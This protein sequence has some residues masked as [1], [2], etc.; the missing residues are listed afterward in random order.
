MTREI[1]IMRMY[2][3]NTALREQVEALLARVHNLEAWGA[4][5]SHNSSK[6]SAST[7]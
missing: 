2:A 3:E 1:E 5:G 4:K 6:P 7:G